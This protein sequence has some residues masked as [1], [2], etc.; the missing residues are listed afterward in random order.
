MTKEA[1]REL[2][3]ATRLAPNDSAA[4]ATLGQLRFEL[5]RP[6]E[7]SLAYRAALDLDPSSEE[8]A[9][10]VAAALMEAG[11]LAESEETLTRFLEK[12]PRSAVAWN[13]LGVVR[14]R[15]AAFAGAIEAFRKALAI[16]ETLEAVRLNLARAEQLAAIDRAGTGGL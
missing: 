5:K 16:D 4:W 6:E 7:A 12:N 11:K 2:A 10:G 13:Q 3:D 8:A 15:R 14:V 9:S 1:E